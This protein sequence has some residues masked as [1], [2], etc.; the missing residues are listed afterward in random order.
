[1]K[2]GNV[3]ANV[4]FDLEEIARKIDVI[5]EMISNG[6]EEKAKEEMDKLSEYIN[7]D[8]FKEYVDNSASVEFIYE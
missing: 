7:S 4:K 8:E 1:M 2:I 6:D 5:E 3:T